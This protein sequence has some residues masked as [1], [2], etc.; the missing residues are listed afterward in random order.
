MQATS[1]NQAATRELVG[2]FDYSSNLKMD[3]IRTSETSINF[4]WTTPRHVTE[5]IK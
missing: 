5:N 2:C 3:A 4:Y 1:K